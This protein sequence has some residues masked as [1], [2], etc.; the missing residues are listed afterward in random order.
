MSKDNIKTKETVSAQ[1]VTAEE[2]KPNK[3]NTDV[4][5]KQS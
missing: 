2:V 1:L 5:K 4:K 3:E